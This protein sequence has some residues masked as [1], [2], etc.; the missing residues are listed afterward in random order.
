MRR[1]EK[2]LS[3]KKAAENIVEMVRY[4]GLLFPLREHHNKFY[5]HLEYP[6]VYVYGSDRD[7]VVMRAKLQIDLYRY[8][9]LSLENRHG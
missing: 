3:V 2:T 6:R 7:D 1:R 5:V 9:Q 4:R 8:D